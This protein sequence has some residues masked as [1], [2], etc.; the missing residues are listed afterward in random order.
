VTSEEPGKRFREN[1][2]RAARELCWEK[3]SVGLLDAYSELG[4]RSRA[5]V[6][7]SS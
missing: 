5:S 1:L 6:S 4:T 7:T 3:Q 2:E